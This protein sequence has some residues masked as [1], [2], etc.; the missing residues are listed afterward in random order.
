MSVRT[1]NISFQDTLLTAMDKVAK[2]ES[3]SRSELVREAVRMYIE[4]RERWNS[5]FTLTRNRLGRVRVAEQD[6]LDEIRSYRAQ[7]RR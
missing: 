4:R 3:R 7:R 5:I 1:V 6:I 2:S